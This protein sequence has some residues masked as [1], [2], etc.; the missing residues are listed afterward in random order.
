MLPLQ[1]RGSYRTDEKDFEEFGGVVSVGDVR[2]F[3][4]CKGL[5]YLRFVALGKFRL[6]VVSFTIG[7]LILT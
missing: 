2:L 7:R 1:H 3:I 6:L 4:L 5:E